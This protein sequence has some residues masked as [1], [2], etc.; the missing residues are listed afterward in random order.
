MNT[1]RITLSLLGLAFIFCGIF[2]VMLKTGDYFPL[3]FQFTGLILCI[4]AA[5]KKDKKE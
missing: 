3:T 4:V 2:F 5:A 1:N